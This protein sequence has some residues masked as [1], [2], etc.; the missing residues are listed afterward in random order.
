M[1]VRAYIRGADAEKISRR[2]VRAVQEFLNHTSADQLVACMD[3]KANL[4][5]VE[6][7]DQE[8]RAMVATMKTRSMKLRKLTPA[9]LDEIKDLI[10]QGVRM[11]N[12]EQRYGITRQTIYNHLKPA[13][14]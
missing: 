6:L 4:I 5:L 2:S 12:I 3:R 9:A 8:V 7:T 11:K 1:R 10:G 13:K 14:E